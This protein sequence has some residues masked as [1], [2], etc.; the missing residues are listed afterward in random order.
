MSGVWCET[1]YIYRFVQNRAFKIVQSI[2]YKFQTLTE[3][4]SVGHTVSFDPLFTPKLIF[5]FI[6]EFDC[7]QFWSKMTQ[8][9]FSPGTLELLIRLSFIERKPSGYPKN[10]KTSWKNTKSKFFFE[11]GQELVR[12]AHLKAQWSNFFED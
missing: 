5:E 6:F 4:C 8:G 2:S 7:S 9:S 3:Y 12:T 10:W 1:I 11:I